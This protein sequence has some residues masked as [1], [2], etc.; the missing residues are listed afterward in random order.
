MDTPLH[1]LAV[2]DADAATLKQPGQ[3]AREV[4]DAISAA[5]GRLASHRSQAERESAGAGAVVERI[6][7][8]K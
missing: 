8:E 1:A 7:N 2:P 5:L 4:V 3:A 6:A